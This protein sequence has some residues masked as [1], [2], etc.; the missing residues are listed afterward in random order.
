MEETTAARTARRLRDQAEFMRAHYGTPASALKYS[1]PTRAKPATINSWASLL[2]NLAS[3]LEGAE[4]AEGGQD[5]TPDEH[6]IVNAQLK[7]QI[8]EMS[9]A[10]WR[11]LEIYRE[12]K[13]AL[14][15]DS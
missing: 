2:E 9:S 1:T 7:G 11:A 4:G 8:S 13:L 6:R 5:L 15:E 12:M 10:S 3:H 14:E